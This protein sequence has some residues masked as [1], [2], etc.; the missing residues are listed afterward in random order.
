MTAAAVLASEIMTRGF[1]VIP[2]FADPAACQ[3]MHGMAADL[4]AGEHAQRYPKSTRVWDLYRHGQPFLDVLT[5]PLLVELL[6]ALLGEYYLLSDFSLNVLEPGQP[7]DNWHIDYPYNE[8]RTIVT[9]SVLGLQCVLALD[10]FDGSNGGTE[11]VPGSHIPPRAPDTEQTG[12]RE[13]CTMKAG[14]LLVMVAAAWHRSGFNSSARLR[15]AML[16]SFVEKWVRPMSGPP[17]PGPWSATEQLA[18]VLG[19]R[20]PPEAIDGVPI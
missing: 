1:T 10:D 7:I 20:R 8:M 17:E 14:S 4:A 15:S 2:G 16:L 6:T 18:T 11:I 19:I 5:K 12:T 9:G 3:A 13:I